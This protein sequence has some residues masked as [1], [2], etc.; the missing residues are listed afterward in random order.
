MKQ[1]NFDQKY[2]G[3]SRRKRARRGTCLL[4][5]TALVTAWAAPAYGMP[6]Y[7]H[8]PEGCS[9]ET[10][11]RMQ[12]DLVEWDEIGDLVQ[13]YNP[14]YTAA[15]DVANESAVMLSGAYSSF[16]KD[17][18]ETLETTDTTIDGLREQQKQ[19]LGLPAGT[20]VTPATET[21]P[22]VTKEQALAQLEK[23]LEQAKDGRSQIASGIRKTS[24]TVN[25]TPKRIERQLMPVKK[26]MTFAMEGVVISY[27]QLKINREMVAAQVK[28][29]ETVYATQQSME[30][31]GLATGYDVLAAKNNLE[32]ARA[33][34]TQIDSG[35]ETV[36][37]SIGLQLGW[38]AATLP[39]IGAVPEPEVDYVDTTNPDADKTAAIMHNSEVRAA[40]KPAY[41]SSYGYE[42]RDKTENEKTGM[43][44]AKMDTLYADMK[45]KKAL[46]TAAET[47]LEKA[48]LTKESAER[49]YELGMLGRSEY[50]AQELAY[51]SYEASYKLAKL[52]L[53]QSI[54]TYQWAVDGV[55][56]LD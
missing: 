47:T 32:Q 6:P 26:S 51:I 10:W 14:T 40:G 8:I 46:F 25:N 31:Q 36:R 18:Q 22:E 41:S 15:F 5:L 44:V 53:F 38:D 49:R 56:T 17:M 33:S 4:L 2:T 39:E 42:L 54:N 12:D 19:L 52:N 43:L 16:V 35:M 7:D 28:L 45:E 24:D 30:Q 29:Y 37:R 9:E 23:G 34:L 3:Q 21:T 1:R 20:V 55:V 27:E 13:Y 50:E 48:R 11:N